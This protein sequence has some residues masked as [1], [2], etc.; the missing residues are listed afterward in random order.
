[1]ADV[2][3]AY[4]DRLG[5]RGLLDLDDVLLRAGDLLLG[6]ETFAEQAHWRYR[7][8][9]V[10]EFQDVNPA[11]FRLVRAVTGP[12]ADLCVVGDPN[13][14]I[15]GWNGADP[16]LLA[17]L[18]RVV[19]GLAVVHL[20]RNHR[21]S[22]QIVAAAVAG[23]GPV[24]VAPP[25]SA[26]PDGP[27]PTVTAFDDEATEAAAVAARI[28][29]RCD[30]GTPW[31]SQAVLARTHEQLAVVRRAL[32]AVGV[33]CRFAPAPDAPDVQGP[34]AVPPGPTRRSPGSVTTAAR[35]D[36]GGAVELATFHRAKG[37]EW[38]AVSVVG[39]EQGFVP[40]VHAV[41]PDAEDEERRLLYVAL[42][43]AG[44]GPRVLVG[45][46]PHHGLGARHG[47]ST[48]TVARRAGRRLHTG[49]GPPGTHRCRQALRRPPV[50]PERLSGAGSVR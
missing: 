26:A 32:D 40:I 49:R 2:Y 19:P 25:D 42:T 9:A 37:L 1:M 5:R 6:D 23:L 44:P 24:R 10:D 14:A 45:P 16:D 43:R 12:G 50:Q 36:V 33:P 29:A 27:V 15:Y 21:C 28:L 39:L 47:T 30:A 17:S 20:D 34:A 22:P 31:S 18:D 46:Q 8:L 35:G 3:R 7:H 41:T 4:Q 48:V 38:D 11:Q 13:Q